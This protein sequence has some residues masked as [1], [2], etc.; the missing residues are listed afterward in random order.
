MRIP[1]ITVPLRR[2]NDL[3]FARQRARQIAQLLGFSTGDSTR[4]TTALA[5]IARNALVYGRGGTVAFFIADEPEGPQALVVQVVDEGPGVADLDTVLAGEYGSQT[6]MGLGI[7]G[8]RALMDRFHIESAAGA[9][10][11]VL[12]SKVLPRSTPRIGTADVARLT[13]ALIAR[14]D[15]SPFGELQLQ[16][17]ELLSALDE[18]TRRQAEIERL[19]LAAEESRARAEAARLVAERSVAVQERFMALTTHEIRTPL[20]AMLGYLELLEMELSGTLTEKQ[21][22]H[23]LRMQRACKHLMGVTND[24]LLMAKGQAGHLEIAR[25]AGTARHVISEAAALVA[26]QAA[27][28]AVEITLSETTDRVMYLGDSDRVRQVLVNLLGNAVSFTP[29]GGSIRVTAARVDD[30][31]AGG[32]LLGGPWCAVRVDDSGPG[33][34]PDKL[35]R[36]FEPFV[37]VASGGQA[38]R[39]G[40]G[41][42]LTVS[43][44]LALLMGGDLTAEGSAGIGGGAAFTL[45][46][47]DGTARSSPPEATHASR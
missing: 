2:Q 8:S 47:A 40:T 31:P 43:R 16:N 46:L 12:M 38:G 6:G 37:Q 23:F 34:P 25:H 13:D 35:P 5:E 9:G 39:R 21:I 19:G 24:F 30:P 18:I 44:Q 36:V 32:E 27:A 17:Q 4:I 3:L 42:G 45:W 41:L 15:G 7:T 22:G 33:I 28:R 29:S 10:T 1:L 26:P 11:R 20:N 14:G